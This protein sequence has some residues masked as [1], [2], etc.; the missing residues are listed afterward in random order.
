MC[1][2]KKLTIVYT[3]IFFS[4]TLLATAQPSQ[5]GKG[6]I[7]K[8]S[9]L[10]GVG[11]HDVGLL[12]LLIDDVGGAEGWRY[13]HIWPDTL[14]MDHL[15]WNWLAIG[16][17]S[18]NVSDGWD[19]DWQTTAG[20][21]MIITEPGIT[22][23]EEGYAQ[24]HDLNNSIEVT[25]ESYA[26]ADPPHDDYVIVKYT[27]K[28]VGYSDFL[29]L[30]AGHRSDFDV[31][32]DHGG[33]QTDMSAF[34]S[35]RNLAYMYDYYGDCHVGV[36]L[37]EGNYRGYRTGWY[38]ADD[39]E[40]FSALSTAGAEPP[41]IMPDDWCFWLSVGPYAVAQGDSI[42]IAFA[43]LA[44]EDLS[45]LQ[46]NADTAQVKWN[47]LG[48]SET[49][50][51]TE[52][53]TLIFLYVYPNPF[54]SRINFECRTT[55][56]NATLKIYTVTGQLVNL[57]TLSSSISKLIWDGLDDQGRPVPNGIYI[58]RLEGHTVSISKKI[59]LLR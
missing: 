53:T 44:G 9:E 31:L 58:C 33:S 41:T 51:N 36:K 42:I 2:N 30:Y 45:D 23:D 8:S 46:A 25:Q 49:D 55:D 57:F 39:A 52:I 13:T 32:G 7:E 18:D 43:F 14:T 54:T 40:K 3:L 10:T 28:N 16:Y 56:T 48:I 37:L 1:I 29:T 47:S 35:T 38:V 17:S 12:S 24:Y 50:N 21:T 26:W 20:G 59:I 34:D 15:Y 22:A 4:T 5:C 27:I 19:G 6:D 11:L